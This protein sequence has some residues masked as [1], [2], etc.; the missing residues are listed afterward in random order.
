MAFPSRKT[1]IF[2]R[3]E[4]FYPVEFCGVKSAP[5]EAADHAALNPGT[6]RVEDLDGTVLWSKELNS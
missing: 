6:L 3:E 2:F 4:G 1:V 5:E